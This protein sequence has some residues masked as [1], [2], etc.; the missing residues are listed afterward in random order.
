MEYLT[1]KFPELFR[2][3]RKRR[4]NQ[5]ENFDAYYTKVRVAGVAPRLDKEFAQYSLR[6]LFL[7]NL[8]FVMLSSIILTCGGQVL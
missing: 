7:G 8:Q 2:P 4:H 1:K 3:P 5:I 6:C